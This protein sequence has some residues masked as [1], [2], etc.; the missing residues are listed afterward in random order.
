MLRTRERHYTGRDNGGE[1]ENTEGAEE[2]VNERERTGR[3][4]K[5][6]T[7]ITCSNSSTICCDMTFFF[8]LLAAPR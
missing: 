7:C 1:E 2:R 4:G 3:G 6:Q 5:G 8:L